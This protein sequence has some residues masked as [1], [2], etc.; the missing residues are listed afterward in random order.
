MNTTAQDRASVAGKALTVAENTS[1]LVIGSGPAG[2]AAAIEAARRGIA[3]TLVDENPVPFETMGE[4]IPL[5]FGQR[6]GGIVRNRTAMTEAVLEQAPDIAVAFEAGV[7]VRLGTVAWGLYVPQPAAAW[8]PGP[9]CGLADHERSWLIGFDH[10]IVAAGRRDMGLA[11]PGWEQ[12]GVMGATAAQRLASHGALEART[13]VILGSS[14]EALLA[15]SALLDAGIDV[16]AIVERA[17][18]VAG[19]ADLANTITS[20]GVPILTGHVV[21]AA[22]GGLDG[23]EAVRIVAVDAEGRHFAGTER[24]IACDTVVLGIAAIPAI[25]L[26]EAAGCRVGFDGDRGGHVPLTGEGYRCSLPVIQAIGDCA[27]VWP[28]KSR[29]PEIARTE[30]LIAVG[31]IAGSPAAELPPPPV[32][33]AS[34]ADLAALRC[35]WVRASVVEA[36]GEPHVCQCEEVTARE[37]LEVKPPRYLNWTA[38]ANRPTDLAALLGEGP[39]SA[40]QIKRLTRAGMGPCQGRR[41]REQVAALLALGSGVPLETMPL[42]TFRAP[43]RPLPLSLLAESAED[44]EITAHW[45]SWFGMAAQWVPYWRVQPGYTAA[46]RDLHSPVASE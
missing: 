46:S 17:G 13:A 10:C 18:T 4:E 37:I 11:F 27:G 34:A 44:P 1:L 3:V 14:A 20:A 45:D 43:V 26:L 5:H 25:E 9:V 36:E 35:G 23:V 38:P 42:A 29:N 41:C 8:M 12:P 16:A 22:D 2:L 6:M 7:D 19:P 21:A 31:A 33:D 40:D 24:T 28:S 15:A 32:P 30:A 39:P